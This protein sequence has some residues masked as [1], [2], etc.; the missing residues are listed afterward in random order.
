MKIYVASSA[1]DGGVHEYEYVG[2]EIKPIRTTRIPDPMFLALSG[3]EMH[4]VF[5]E[6]GNR[7]D[8][9][10][11]GVFERTDD[12]LKQKGEIIS[13]RGV[14][15]CHL[16]VDG[17]QAYVVNYLSGSVV[18]LPDGKRVTHE[19][20][21]VNLPRQASAHTHMALF[22]RD[23]RLVYVT[24][25]GLD[26]IFV[27]DRDLN[28]LSRATVPLGYGA[29]HLVISH[30]GKYLYCVNELVSSVSSFAIDGDRLEYLETAL[31]P[32]ETTEKNTAGAIRLS[33]DGR[34]LYISNRGENTL[35]SFAVDGARLT[36]K[37]KVDCRGNFPRDFDITPDGKTLICCNQYTNDLTIFD[38]AG[39]GALA[40]R[41]TIAGLSNPLCVIFGE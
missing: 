12:G 14:V 10:G 3:D 1:K 34:T 4:V 17:D 23:K 33:A 13:S 36:M 25:L 37:Q 22:S 35:V 40:Y 24:D 15:P 41:R 20:A 31:C 26:T 6:D 28:E 30:D 38:V 21:G 7:V 2:G 8:E 16:S 32:I 5:S 39:D 29:R 18:R 19:G 9:G 11:Y 27:Y